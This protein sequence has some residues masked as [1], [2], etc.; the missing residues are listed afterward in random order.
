MN[1]IS[2]KVPGSLAANFAERLAL[3]RV[4]KLHHLEVSEEEIRVERLRIGDVLDMRDQ[5]VDENCEVVAYET[6]LEDKSPDELNTLF[7]HLHILKVR[8]I[9]LSDEEGASGRIGEC[10]SL[11][12][13]YGIRV[14]LENHAGGRLATAGDAEAFLKDH[15]DD[16]PGIVFN[17]LEY[18][19]TQRH[20]FFHV[21]YASRMKNH[22]QMLRINDGLFSDGTAC[23]P[24]H[25]N[26]E[27]KEL[28]SIML[29]RSFDGVFSIVPC[30]SDASADGVNKVL[31]WLRAVLKSM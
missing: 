25:G 17:P 3:L 15:K 30:P 13:S 31:S 8:N 22:I 6:R 7:Q 16:E 23:F 18:V 12:K 26:G 29:S 27:V 20:P 2:V 9:L 5:L 1:A 24:G 4:L 21:Y 19:R 11:S 10:F 14:L 28:I